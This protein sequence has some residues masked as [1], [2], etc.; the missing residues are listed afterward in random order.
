MVKSK[1]MYSSFYRRSR[2]LAR[3]LLAVALT[4][5]IAISFFVDRF[6]TPLQKTL[7]M[8]AFAQ[9]PSSNTTQKLSQSPNEPGITVTN[10][11]VGKGPTGVAVNPS[12]NTVYVADSNSNTTSIIDGKTNSVVKTVKVGYFPSDVAVNPN[13][14]MVYVVNRGDYSIS[15]INGN[16]NTVVKNIIVGVSTWSVDINPNTNMIY[17]VADKV[18][19]INGNTNTVVGTIN[20]GR[21]PN[22]ATVNPITNMVYVSNIDD[23]TVSV[24]NGNTNTVSRNYQGG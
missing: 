23:N 12:T 22:S 20:A 17:A 18:F 19:I 6:F 11:N 21:T 8:E 7:K 10:V 14:N 15:V 1:N 9:I 24:I 5:I 16:T 4:V 2:L 3:S 13:T